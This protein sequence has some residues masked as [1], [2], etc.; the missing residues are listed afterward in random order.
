MSGQGTKVHR[1]IAESFN[2]LSRVHE[3]YRRQTDK[4]TDGRPMTYSDMNL[5]SR[6]LKTTSAVTVNMALQRPAA[7]SSTYQTHEASLAVDGNLDTVSCT[8][9]QHSQE[10]WLSVDLGAPMDVARVCVV[11]DGHPNYGQPCFVF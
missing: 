4:Q 11:N 9:S 2:R 1:N 10:P 5:S 6:S 3:R 8:A 7:Q